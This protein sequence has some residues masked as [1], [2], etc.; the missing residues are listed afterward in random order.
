MPAKCQ[1][2][3]TTY[4]DDYQI[5]ADVTTSKA[6]PI[7]PLNGEKRNNPHPLQASVHTHTHTHIYIYTYIDRHALSCI[8]KWNIL[9]LPGYRLV[10]L[11]SSAQL[12]RSYVNHRLLSTEFQLKLNCVI[13]SECLHRS[14]LIRLYLEIQISHITVIDIDRIHFE[15]LYSA[16]MRIS[17]TLT[18]PWMY[19]VGCFDG[20][21][22]IT[23]NR[24]HSPCQ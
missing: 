16:C 6:H 22:W 23:R 7:Y 9:C 24:Y 12:I 3:H 17:L 11:T 1:E 18:S 21:P 4:G 14:W 5:N 8:L 13:T 2:M 15:I 10:M 19:R 20:T